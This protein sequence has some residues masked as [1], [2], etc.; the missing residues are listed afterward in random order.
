MKTP[1]EKAQFILG[2]IFISPTELSRRYPVLPNS[3]RLLLYYPIHLRDVVR[4]H[5]LPTLRLASG[6]P[7]T[8][9][10]AQSMFQLQGWKKDY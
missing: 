6:D 5:L 4:K 10:S 3:P 7:K 8:V 2:R 9:S 1:L